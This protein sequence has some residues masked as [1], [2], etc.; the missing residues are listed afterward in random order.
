M[1]GKEEMADG[2][3][4][5]EFVICGGEERNRESEKRARVVKLI[6]V[7][8]VCCCHFFSFSLFIYCLFIILL[9]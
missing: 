8:C 1:G 6:G 3:P 9:Y 7:H 5:R 2:I 4:R